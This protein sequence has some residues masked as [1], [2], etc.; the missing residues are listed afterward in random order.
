MGLGNRGRFLFRVVLYSL[1]PF[2]GLY[3][4][5]AD[6]YRMEGRLLGFLGMSVGF[7]ALY[8]LFTRLSDPRSAIDYA[9]R[10]QRIAR[11][12]IR[13][14][15]LKAPQDE[16]ANPQESLRSF[17]LE[18]LP[19]VEVQERS[20][21]DNRSSALAIGEDLIVYFSPTLATPR[22]METLIRVVEELRTPLREETVLILLV[23]ELP[24]Q[25]EAQM[26]K[27]LPRVHMM[28]SAS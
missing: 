11:Q 18:A 13:Q 25:L 9:L 28:R 22:D 1:A 10:P 24:P 3:V 23:Q 16:S 2:V 4:F 8:L 5:F 6:S 14:W 19:D 20:T 12:L 7:L 21:S 26:L 17:L 27:G 15:Q